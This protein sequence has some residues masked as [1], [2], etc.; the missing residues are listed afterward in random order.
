MGIFHD[1]Q[2]KFPNHF[3]K[4]SVAHVVKVITDFNNHNLVGFKAKYSHYCNIG[5]IMK[6]LLIAGASSLIIGLGMSI[7]PTPSQAQIANIKSQL[8]SLPTSRIAFAKGKTSASIN[9]ADNRIYILR[10]K[11][12]QKLTLRGDNFGARAG[13][14][15]YG[16]N[17]KL[18]KS[19]GGFSENKTFVYRLP[20]TGDY[21][22]LGYG[23]ST[24]HIY[25]FTVTIK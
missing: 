11:A 13:V 12:G 4:T 24:N 1:N 16:T 21:Y 25:D 19:F 5:K 14:T 9:G 17:G 20:S 23:G 7:V 2:V 6:R 15:F 18:L 10:A 8:N 3:R 22:I